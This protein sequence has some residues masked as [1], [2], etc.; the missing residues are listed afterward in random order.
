MLIYE[1]EYVVEAKQSKKF[2]ELIEEFE[3]EVKKSN[4]PF[5]K[6]WYFLSKKYD[7][8]HVRNVWVLEEQAN[9]DE[10]WDKYPSELGSLVP[11]IWECIVE[12]T[13]RSSFWYKVASK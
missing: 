11:K 3:K 2:L 6:D 9:V 12:G 1:E 8:G 5:L 7:I 13:Y 10:L 4:I